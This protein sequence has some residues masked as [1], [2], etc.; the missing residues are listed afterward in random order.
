ME[1]DAFRGAGA[2][3]GIRDA[4]LVRC[5]L[6][7]THICI[8]CGELGQ[9]VT[10]SLAALG[11]GEGMVCRACDTVNQSVEVDCKYAY[12]GLLKNEV[13]GFN[14]KIQHRFSEEALASL[15]KGEMDD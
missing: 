1:F 9:V 8:K 11:A 12:A 13:G 4:G 10:P 7:K 5:D 15:S 2:A 6:F 14:I 3:Y